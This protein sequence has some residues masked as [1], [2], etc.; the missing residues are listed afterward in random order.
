MVDANIFRIKKLHS[1]KNRLL[2]KIVIY[3][4]IITL[5]KLCKCKNNIKFILS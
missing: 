2:D 1:K 4:K 5:T 3:Y